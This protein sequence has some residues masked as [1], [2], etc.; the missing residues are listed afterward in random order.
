[1]CHHGSAKNQRNL[2]VFYQ[3]LGPRSSNPWVITQLETEPVIRRLQLDSKGSPLFFRH[4]MSRWQM[5][6]NTEKKCEII[7][8]ETKHQVRGYVLNGNLI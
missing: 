8:R 1:M 5:Q 4:W 3:L 6:L 2:T 7:S